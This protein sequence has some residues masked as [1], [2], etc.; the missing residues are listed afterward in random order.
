MCHILLSHVNIFNLRV[1]IY[2]S[3]VGI[4]IHKGNN[5]QRDKCEW[6]YSIH[7]HVM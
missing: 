1:K 5:V 4:F 3:H 7:E 6:K 2:I